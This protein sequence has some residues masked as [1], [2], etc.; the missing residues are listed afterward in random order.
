MKSLAIVGRGPVGAAVAAAA[1]A[2]GWDVSVTGREVE[3]GSASVVV[4]AI[5]GRA[6]GE[7]LDRHGAA[8]AGRTVIDATNH[9][10][11][12]PTV[13]TNIRPPFHQAEKF[14][15]WAPDAT[16][17]RALCTLGWE[18]IGAGELRPMQPFAAPESE[19]E[20]VEGLL[21][22]LGLDPVWVGEGSQALAFVDS[23]TQ[24]WLGLAFGTPR[25]RRVALQ[26]A[27]LPG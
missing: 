1:G 14:T 18:S 21:A 19:R 13:I 15:R 23:A 27:R 16:Y 11:G 5:P 24:L 2:A 25:G 6:V 22:D 7:F 26:L 10:A 8:L 4:L 17:V 9:L 20:T 12:P 3:L